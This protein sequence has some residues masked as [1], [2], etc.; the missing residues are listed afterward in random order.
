MATG[1]GVTLCV[2][3]DLRGGDRD[4]FAVRL[5]AAGQPFDP[6][7]FPLG[8]GP[9]DQT[10]PTVAFNGTD[11]LVAWKSQ[12]PAA[13]YY[14]DEVRAVRVSPLGLVRDAVPIALPGETL[15]ALC[16][17][18]GQGFLVVTTGSTSTTVRGFRIDGNGTLRDPQGIVLQ[19]GSSSLLFSAS[20]AWA[21]GTWLLCWGSGGDVFGQRFGANLQPLDPT[22]VG[23]LTSARNE[24]QP[25]LASNGSQFLLTTWDNDIYWSQ[26]VSAVRFS[27]TLQR[28][29][30]TPIQVSGQAGYQPRPQA[31]WDGSQWL[32]SWI[33]LPSVRVARLAAN[34]AV[35]DPGGIALEPTATATVYTP[36]LAAGT[37]G[38]AIAVWQD[39]R[40]ASTA[41]LFAA[42]LS[43]GGNPGP[44]TLVGRATRDQSWPALASSPAGQLLVFRSALST[45]AA[46]V[47]QRLDP[48]GEF[49]DRQPI[50]VGIGDGTS[51][52]AVAFDGGR[53]LVCWNVGTQVVGRRLAL[54]GTFLEAAPFAVM[55][56][57][58]PDVAGTGGVFLVVN[59]RAS[60][61]PQYVDPYAMR[62]RGN[63]GALLDAS[64][65]L[66]GSSYAVGPRVAALN[67]RFVVVYEQ[68]WS[69]N[70]TSATV[71][72]TMVD[73]NGTIGTPGGLS[74]ITAS[75]WGA[76]DVAADGN[77]ALIVWASGS[78]WTN[79]DVFAQRLNANGAPVG[80][81]IALSTNAAS[82][83]SRPAVAF[84]GEQFLVAFESLQNNAR[85][86]DRAPDVYVRRVATDGTLPDA[87][88]VPVWTGMLA[89]RAV[90]IAGSGSDRGAALLAGS[91][92]RVDGGFASH[93]VAVRAAEPMGLER[94]GTGTAG[95]AGALRLRGGSAAHLATSLELLGDRLPPQG[96]A[97]WLL[98]SVADR[99]GSDPFGLGALLHVALPGAEVLVGAIDAGGLARLSL[100]VPSLPALVGTTWTAQCG[101]VFGPC[102]PAA[103]GLATSP[104][105]SFTVLP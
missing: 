56:G 20:L 46:I 2:F 81:V 30:A 44:V 15:W 41:D 104:G 23:L 74:T 43:A 35:L 19:S 10:M 32:V 51:R 82:G 60:V 21:S 83:Q 50:L 18:D 42:S 79:E 12:E 17:S 89:D 34:G 91:R 59:A 55:A 49:V 103:P 39:L 31:V 61:Y 38:G 90:A 73:P 67:G 84:D 11:F 105:L 72:A 8:I 94:F 13:G 58:A 76:V 69:H 85:F 99:P 27:P 26:G 53:Y 29:D 36:T 93:R 22:P 57:G 96:L 64:P 88:A 71:V 78:N 25:H 63:D 77:Q 6:V 40:H 80:P 9:G 101:A 1:G 87:A 5:D 3:D 4:V 14:Q 33:G 95:C 97:F 54:D 28:L 48:F 16:A 24:D 75:A 7:P 65:R 92:F 86:Y 37:A 102:M 45:D 66:V 47:A 62:I 68:H 52:P 100:S 98:G 70:Q